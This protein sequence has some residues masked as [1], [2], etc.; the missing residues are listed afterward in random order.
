MIPEKE[1]I[2]VGVLGGAFDPITN[3]HID[4]AKFVLEKEVV[5]QVWLMPCFQHCFGKKMTSD[6]HRLAMCKIAT[7]S[8][9]KIGVSDLEIEYRLKGDTYSLIKKMKSNA[10]TNKI[11]DFTIIIGQDNANRFKEWY[12]YE[13]LM[14][15]IRFIVVPRKGVAP[16]KDWYMKKPHI[17][18]NEPTNI[19]D[20]S[21]TIVRNELAF[22]KHPTESLR[23]NV[24]SGVLKYIF[25]HKLYLQ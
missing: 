19:S 5:E 18:L 14:E 25:K 1:K 8:Y 9:S 22:A 20:V 7:A 6:S 15:M 10:I 13:E 2:Q 17:F 23:L 4:L 12:K 21:S 16:E 11:Y 24:P 3:G